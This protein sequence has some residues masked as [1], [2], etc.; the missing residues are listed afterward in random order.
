MPRSKLL[1]CELADKLTQ[2]GTFVFDTSSCWTAPCPVMR[3]PINT[4]CSSRLSM[5]QQGGA[6]QVLQQCSTIH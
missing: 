5:Q 1:A 3:S 4:A 2:S 6:G